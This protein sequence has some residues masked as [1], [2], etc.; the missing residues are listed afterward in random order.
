[1]D[2]TWHRPDF[3][4]KMDNILISANVCLCLGTWWWWVNLF[5]GGTTIQGFAYNFTVFVFKKV[6]VVVFG[7]PWCE[8][9]PSRSTVAP[10]ILLYAC[11]LFSILW[12]MPVCN[13]RPTSSPPGP[14]GHPLFGWN[15]ILVMCWAGLAYWYWCF[16]PFRYGKANYTC[17]KRADA[18]HSRNSSFKSQVTNCFNVSVT[19]IT[20]KNMAYLMSVFFV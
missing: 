8:L 2:E 4:V 16:C 7:Q 3:F 1:M 10:L 19:I 14:D 17:R 18:S 6:W 13:I 9:N 12:G 20:S 5:R 15:W 11:I